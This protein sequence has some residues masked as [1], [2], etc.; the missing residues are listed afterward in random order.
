VTI[1]LD[2]MGFWTLGEHGNSEILTPNIDAFAEHGLTFTN[3]YCVSPVCSPA[4]PRASL[5]AG[6]IPSQHRVQDWIRSESTYRDGDRPIEY[7]EGM[8]GLTDVLAKNGY[9]CG[10]IGK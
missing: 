8:P 5:L 9:Y 3:C 10:Q 6:W 4:R 2:D 7:L 1:L